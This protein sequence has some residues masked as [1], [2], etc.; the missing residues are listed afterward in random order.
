MIVIK[1]LRDGH[2][3]HMD[4][5]HAASCGLGVIRVE[6]PA[7]TRI[8]QGEYKRVMKEAFDKQGGFL[9]WQRNTY[10]VTLIE[11][12]ADQSQGERT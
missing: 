2:Y 12:I 10:V 6:L 7:N 8:S 9:P 3:F 4:V 11:P 5:K 1:Q